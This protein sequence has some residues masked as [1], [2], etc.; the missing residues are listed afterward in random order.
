MVAWGESCSED[1]PALRHP[2]M[3][4]MGVP[5]RCGHSA[6]KS[7]RR[8]DRYSV[9][10]Q[11]DLHVGAARNQTGGNVAGLARRVGPQHAAQPLGK[12]RPDPV[13]LLEA[14]P[15]DVGGQ[16]VVGILLAE[17]AHL[18]RRLR[19][20]AWQQQ[21]RAGADPLPQDLRLRIMPSLVGGVGRVEGDLL[22]GPG[23]LVR[24]AQLDVQVRAPQI[25]QF[26]IQRLPQPKVN[27]ER[28]TVP[29]E[30]APHH[31]GSEK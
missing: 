16:Q 12:R 31:T 6:S 14:Q 27:M 5:L 30:R 15:V 23:A 2:T 20:H 1:S 10:V 13:D 11:L 7:T 29:V 22:I 3:K 8:L 26:F 25:A 4:I 24:P 17:Q 21:Q 18:A 19:P 9:P 28:G